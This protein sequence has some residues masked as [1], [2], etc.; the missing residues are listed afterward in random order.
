MLCGMY[1]IIIMLY[2][3]YNIIIMLCGMYNI[4]CYVVCIIFPVM[5]L[6][7]LVLVTLIQI[8]N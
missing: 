8:V 2:G 1:N 4:S 5:L 7:C 6:T 3:M